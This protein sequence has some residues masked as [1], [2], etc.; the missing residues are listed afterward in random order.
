MCY[1]DLKGETGNSQ[2]MS[3]VV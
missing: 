2:G 3:Q 1:L